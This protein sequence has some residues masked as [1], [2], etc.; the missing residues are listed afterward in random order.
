[1]RHTAGN[2]LAQDRSG[3]WSS[4]RVGA[5]NSL[6]SARGWAGSHGAS[7]SE[8]KRGLNRDS[9]GAEA[10][11]DVNL[12]RYRERWAAASLERKGRFGLTSH[13]SLQ[14]GTLTPHI[15]VHVTPN[16][17]KRPRVI[18]KDFRR[19]SAS[20]MANWQCSIHARQASVPICP[21]TLRPCI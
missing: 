15:Q 12:A 6:T 7:A 10:L 11:M 13:S 1:M 16:R 9:G 17:T 2:Q 4:G 5:C 18:P 21:C 14:R 19:I 8:A 20:P 3:F